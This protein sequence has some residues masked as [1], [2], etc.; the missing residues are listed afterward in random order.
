MS[1]TNATTN[2]EL[3]VF[4][5]TDKPAWLVDWNGAMNAI[6]SAI[7]EAKTAGDNAQSTANTNANNIQTL[8]GTVTSQGTAIGNLQTAVSGNT[9]SINTINSL[10]GNGEPTTTDKTIIGAINEINAKVGDVDAEDVDYDNTTSG[11]TATNVQAAIDEVVAGAVTPEANDV[12]YDNTTS[13]LSATNVQDAIDE[14]ASA[15]PVGAEHG[16]YELWKNSN[17]SQN[18]A[19]QDVALTGFDSTKYDAII[20]VTEAGANEN[21]GADWHEFDK[22]VLNVTSYSGHMGAFTVNSGG[23]VSE[24]SREVS[25]ALSGT[26]LTIT[27][28]DGTLSTIATYGTA[29]TTTTNNGVVIPVRILGL[30]HNA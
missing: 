11:L 27:F 6:D 23:T 20:I 7:K 12:A 25:F 15:G 28:T 2:Y 13:G 17:I 5:A 9:G 16:V 30:T 14:L 24:R 18:F 29:P 19:G 22:D 26:T 10:I 3:P 21:N 1:A 8:D 4:I